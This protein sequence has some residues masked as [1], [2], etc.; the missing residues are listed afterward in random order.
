MV[1]LALTSFPFIIRVMYLRW[2][3]IPVT[4]YNVHRAVFLWLVLALLVFFAAFYYHP[5]SYNGM[6][7][8]HIVPVVAERGGT[9]TEVMVKAGERVEP[10]Q[11]LFTTDDSQEQ[12]ALKV[13]EQQVAEIDSSMSSAEAEVRTAEANLAQ[14]RAA[15]QQAEDQLADQEQLRELNSPAF[16]EAEYERATNLRASRDAELA[17][18]QARLDTAEL[19]VSE[20]LP[21]RRE[22]ALA[23]LDRAKVELDLTTVR[24]RV[25]GVVEQMTLD[26]G[27]RAGQTNLGPAMLIVPDRPI[28][29]TAGFTQVARDILH[30][31]MPVEIACMSS[32]NVSM[33]NSILP[34]RV[35]RIQNVIAAGQIAPTGQLI[36]PNRLVDSGDIVAHLELVDPEQVQYVMD[37]S[38]CLVQAYTTHVTGSLEGTPVAHVIETLGVLKALLLRVKAWVALATGVGL[39]G[40]SH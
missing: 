38:N 40:G 12:A 32:L 9:V 22:S 16:R 8:F 7:P 21:A 31:G 28:R 35:T 1:E 39:G 15:L 30:V 27:A 10:G 17:A 13:A 6:L 37:G 23:D 18:A 34:A 29:I 33:S 3:G 4:L 2:R 11:V 14:A 26:V 36:E 25:T 20:V 19:Q 24:S 5:K